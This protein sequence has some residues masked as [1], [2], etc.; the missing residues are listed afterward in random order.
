MIFEIQAF[1]QSLTTTSFSKSDFTSMFEVEK[2]TLMCRM[3]SDFNGQRKLM[4]LWC[5]NKLFQRFNFI[6]VGRIWCADLSQLVGYV[7]SLLNPLLW[8][9]GNSTAFWLCSVDC[10][11][12]IYQCLLPYKTRYLLTAIDWYQN[13]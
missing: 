12:T 3:W 11:K 5:F 2:T 10:D 1:Y 6:T 13:V 4:A 8:V 7:Q 9:L